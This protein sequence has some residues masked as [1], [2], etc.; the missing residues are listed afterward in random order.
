MRRERKGVGEEEGVKR[1]DRKGEGGR[2]EGVYSTS[3]MIFVFPH[4]W[5]VWYPYSLGIC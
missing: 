3:V 5:S 2:G 1:E 4:A